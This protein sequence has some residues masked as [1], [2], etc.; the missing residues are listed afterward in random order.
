MFSAI[1]LLPVYAIAQAGAIDPAAEGAAAAAVEG[2]SILQYIRAGGVLSY[3]LIALSVVA[4]A[5]V[6]RNL[7]ALRLVHLV[8]P[9]AVRELERLLRDQ[10]LAGAQRYA[11]QSAEPSF[12][13]NIFSQSLDRCAT[14]PLGPLE[15]RAAVEDAAHS[16]VDELHRFNDGLGIIAAIGPMLGLLGTVIGMIGAFHTIGS[17][18][19]AARS[20]ELAK[21]M[22]M[23]LVNTAEGLIVA[24]P[25]TVAF[26]LF[27]RRINRL[28][29]EAGRVIERL[30]NQ[31]AARGGA[32]AGAAPQARPR[33][34]AP[35]PARPVA[36]GSR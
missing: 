33:A 26:A 13:T 1:V 34:A 6:I 19:G 15:L 17:L 31:V 8:P 24:I 21:F 3:V 20:S 9:D 23:A 16:E 7:L 11:A 22:S 32:A 27:R 30:V 29:G 12:L 14:S 25:C 36:E 5:L 35:V 2:I 18:E 4:V 28:A 10:D